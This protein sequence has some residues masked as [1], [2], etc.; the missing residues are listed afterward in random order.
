MVLAAREDEDAHALL[1]DTDDADVLAQ[2]SPEEPIVQESRVPRLLRFAAVI[3]IACFSLV[4]LSLQVVSHFI[5]N[6]MMGSDRSSL[7]GVV[8]LMDPN[9]WQPGTP[10]RQVEQ[11]P[12]NGEVCICTDDFYMQRDDHIFPKSG[13]VACATFRFQVGDTIYFE[14][15]VGKGPA[16]FDANLV[17]KYT[18]STVIHAGIVSFVPPEAVDGFQNPDK[19]IVTEALKGNYKRVTQ[20]TLRHVIQRWAFGGYFIRRVDPKYVHFKEHLQDITSYLNS[21]AGQPFDDDMVNPAKRMWATG[22]RYIGVNPDCQERVRAYGM[23][24]SG[25]PGKW[26]CSS[27][28]AWTLAFPGGI[29]MDYKNPYDQCSGPGW[30]LTNM[31]EFPGHL[32]NEQNIWDPHIQWHLPCS[33]MGCW[34]GAPMSARWEGGHPPRSRPTYNSYPAPSPPQSAPP[35]PYPAQHPTPAPQVASGYEDQHMPNGYR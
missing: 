1:A 5:E 18:Q 24:K 19:I 32:M 2:S 34:V 33:A 12:D 8:G 31:Q 27:L 23:Y 11:C 13:S 16:F 22:G 6:G 26:I 30:P 10:Y 9:S 15:P 4:V 14:K 3:T 35:A 29:N 7:R 21:V 17:A 20:Q 28:I 25:G